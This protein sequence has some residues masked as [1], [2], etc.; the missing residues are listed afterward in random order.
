MR[1]GHLLPV[2]ID[3]QATVRRTEALPRVAIP[4]GPPCLSGNLKRGA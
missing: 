1:F 3:I 2:H 4:K